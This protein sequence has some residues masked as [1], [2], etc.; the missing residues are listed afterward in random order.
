M[1]VVTSEVPELPGLA[2]LSLLGRGGLADV[3]L[4]RQEHLERWVAAKVFRVTLADDQAA[5]RFRAECRAIGRLDQYPHVLTVYDAGVLGDGRPYLISERCDGSLHDL[6]GMRGPLPADRVAALG[7]TIGRALRFAHSAGVLHGDVTPQN[8]L[9]RTSGAPVLA[10]F[11]LAVLR[12]HAPTA[13]GFTLL[14]AAPE[15][16]RSGTVIDERADV[17]GLGSTLYT[18]L[19]GA[20]P[21]P[22]LAGEDD[23]TYRSRVR[24]EPAPRPDGATDQ[25][26]GLLVAMLAADPA[27]RPSTDEVITALETAPSR[28]TRP[29]RSGGT[30]VA[31]RPGTDPPSARP[32]AYKP[33]V[34]PVPAPPAQRSRTG[35]AWTPRPR[36]SAEV[37]RPW[38]TRVT[39]STSSPRAGRRNSEPS[40][41]PVP[42]VS[43]AAAPVNAQ[44]ADAG[45]AAVMSP[46]DDVV[47]LAG[48]AAS[49]I[50]LTDSPEP[51]A[52]L[53]PAA[54]DD[55][56]ASTGLA[57]PERSS[58]AARSAAVPSPAG[59]TPD[60]GPASTVDSTGGIGPAGS[61]TV[62]ARPAAAPSAGAA[63]RAR[64]GTAAGSADNDWSATSTGF[65]P[66]TGLGTSV[67]SADS[68]TSAG[69]VGPHRHPPASNLPPATGT[70][71]FSA[72]PFGYGD[73]E[74]D[75]HTFAAPVRV[76]G[77][78]RRRRRHGRALLAAGGATAVLVAGT[79]AVAAWRTVEQDLADPDRPHTPVVPPAGARTPVTPPRA[80]PVDLPPAS[81]LPGST[82]QGVVPG[83]PRPGTARPGAAAS[84]TPAPRRAAPPS[85]SAVPERPSTAGNARRPAPAAANPRPAPTPPTAAPRR[86]AAPPPATSAPGSSARDR[87]AAQTPA[88]APPTAQGRPDPRPGTRAR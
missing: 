74:Q 59:S 21:F 54:S 33:D 20:P 69:V 27:Y 30:L 88:A 8:L 66:F 4:A 77:S 7:S 32:A 75:A 62:G 55:D 46:A 13:A 58:D 16:L 80:A 71:A 41:G 18:V 82:L 79:G 64:L 28:T 24:D 1:S 67:W 72:V 37:P 34:T 9:L 36:K 78:R 48:P 11:G 26:A 15:A 85:R 10:D 50:E 83:P 43:G 31:T 87:P 12:D 47:A 39:R 5:E 2:D 76:P 19:T 49:A 22:P 53:Q 51:A 52:S 60:D 84:A 57:E 56:V 45:S 40:A 17:Y 38:D 6:V 14:H 86:T 29:A 3:Y 68:P 35:R 61:A 42:P 81:V 44:P 23:A 65:A 70:A 25:M 73:D 63:G